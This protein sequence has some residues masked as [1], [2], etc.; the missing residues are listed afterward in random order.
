MVAFDLTDD[1]ENGLGLADPLLLRFDEATPASDATGHYDDGAAPSGYTEPVFL[2]EAP[3][4]FERTLSGSGRLFA[5][6]SIY[7]FD[8]LGADQA[9]TTGS[10]A[11][12]CV[13][14]LDVDAQWASGQHAVLVQQ[15]DPPTISWGLRLELVDPVSRLATVRLYWT[16]GGAMAT[17]AGADLVVPTGPFVAIASREAT[18]DGF[19]VRYAAAGELLGQSLV[20]GQPPDLDPGQAVLVGSD[21]AHHLHGV[22]DQVHVMHRPV[23]HEEAELV[24]YRLRQA[25]PEAYAARRSLAGGVKAWGSDLHLVVQ[26]ELQLEAAVLALAKA[27][28][29]RLARYVLRPDRAW[30][31]ALRYWEQLVAIPTRPGDGIDQRRARVVTALRGRLGCSEEDLQ[32]LLAEALGYESD[33]SLADFATGDVEYAD[34]FDPLVTS[35]DLWVSGHAEHAWLPHPNAHFAFTQPAG[36]NDYLQGDQSGTDDLRYQGWLGQGGVAEANP[37]MYL[38]FIGSG[39]GRQTNALGQS[40][41]DGGKQ[42]AARIEVRAGSTIPA[43]LLVG[44]VVGSIVDDEWLWVGIRNNGGANDL[45]AIRY[46]GAV[47]DASFTTL[48]AGVGALPRVIH[49]EHLGNGRDDLGAYRVK[50]AS[51]VAGLAAATAYDV[52]GGPTRPD[53]GGPAAASPSTVANVTGPTVARWADWWHRAPHAGGPQHLRILRDPT[54][55]GIYD[56]ELAGA[57]LAANLLAQLDGTVI[58]EE[59]GLSLEVGDSL[60]DRDPMEH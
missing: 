45:V 1:A 36:G 20:V 9:G 7:A 15:G 10:V 48:A 58:D 19:V 47:L 33:P 54:D 27:N 4:P 17:V 43:G 22:L 13:V 34:A 18:D 42:I 46:M 14:D 35:G 38:R 50:Q 59:R 12:G 5:A 55:P 21:L 29:R 28:A 3:P 2:Q 57:I 16:S 23:T 53:W 39:A 31:A 60:L 32:A 6:G 41:I 8:P 25:G 24:D 49:V 11:I 37:P 52:A 51:S 44:L 40:A 56:T 30:G 26:R